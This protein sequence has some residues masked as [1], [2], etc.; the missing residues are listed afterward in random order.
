MANYFPKGV[1]RMRYLGR[2]GGYKSGIVRR[3]NSLTLRLAGLYSVWEMTGGQFT[4]EEILEELRPPDLSSG[5][6]RTDWHCP[7]GH[8]NSR[9][10]RAC[11]KCRVV[12]PKCGMLT[13]AALRELG[14][15]PGLPALR[16]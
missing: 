4:G 3:R 6:H 13:R 5:D 8:F 10:R 12:A 14:T 16:P 2:V 9:K 1:E 11:A 15:P 7:C